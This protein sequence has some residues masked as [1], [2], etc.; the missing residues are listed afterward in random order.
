MGYFAVYMLFIAGIHLITTSILPTPGRKSRHVIDSYCRSLKSRSSWTLRFDMPIKKISQIILPLISLSDLRKVRLQNTLRDAEKQLSAEEYVANVASG[1]IMFLLVGLPFAFLSPYIT[2]GFAAF[3]VYYGWT[4]AAD[5]N[6][7]GKAKIKSVES[8][9]PRFASYIK[10]SLK[11]N[12][13]ALLILERYKTD[14][15][16]FAAELN[17]TIADIR[18][19]SFESAILRLG[20]RFNSENLSMIV[21]GIIAI[22]NGDDVRYYFEL[23]EKDFTEMEINRLRREIK[24]IPG[25]MRRSMVVL[26]TAIALMFF[27]PIVILIYESIVK[28]FV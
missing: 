6:R 28:F 4:C 25:K 20:S 12:K 5:L 2:A 27:T 1:C 24:K 19:S 16:D 23:L 8:E 22:Y 10:H 13:S 3:S 7:T 9:L 15:A 18:T 11:N 26:Y 17:K 14:N 21:R